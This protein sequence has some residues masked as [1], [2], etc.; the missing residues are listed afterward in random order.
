MTP[1]RWQAIRALADRLTD[2][3][4]SRRWTELDAACE[5]DDAL[6]DEVLALIDDRKI[7]PEFLQPVSPS[8]A[9]SVLAETVAV[10][11]V[12]RR[13]G[14]YRLSEIIAVGGMGTVYRGLRD[15][16]RFD[17][18]V[19]IKIPHQPLV[20]DEARRRFARELQ[21]V[22]RLE[23]PH[24]ARLLD[25]GVVHEH[26]AYLVMEL[27]DG[28]PLHRCCREHRLTIDQRLTLFGCVCDAV[29]FAHQNLVVHRD[30]KP[31]NILVTKD[32]QV[33][34]VDFGIARLLDD[35]GADDG[36]E[37]TRTAW[38]AFTP[39]YASPEQ[40]RG[41]PVTVAGEVY[42]LGVVLYELLSGRRPYD[43]AGLG[44][45]ELERVIGQVDPT[46]PS[47]AVAADLTTTRP[48]GSAGDPSHDARALRA[49]Q[50]QLEGDL[51]TIVL[52]AL[53]KDPARRYPSVRELAA[54]IDRH[55]HGYPVLARRDSLV[56]RGRKFVRRNLAAVLAVGVIMLSL[57]GGMVVATCGVVRAQRSARIAAA[58]SARADAAA[59]RAMEIA[60]MLEGL[61]MSADPLGPHGSDVRVRDLLAEAE[62]RIDGELSGKPDLQ[63]VLHRIVGSGY[64][65][66][67]LLQ[68]AEP[69]LRAAVAYHEAALD[70]GPNARAGTPPGA[71]PVERAKATEALAQWLAASGDVA[72]AETLF[73]RALAS[74]Q[75]LPSAPDTATAEARIA[76]AD[77]LRR[78]QQYDEAEE[79]LRAALAI[80]R[81]V[82]GQEHPQVAD[83]LDR[84][85]TVRGASNDD[86]EAEALLRQ[87]LAIRLAA[88]GASSPA[89]AT[90][91]YQLARLHTRRGEVEQADVCYGEVM[92]IYEALAP[93][94]RIALIRPLFEWTGVLQQRG[95]TVE[96]EALLVDALAVTTDE[97]PPW[98]YIRLLTAQR[99]SALLSSQGR[100]AEAEPHLLEV[101]R[102]LCQLIGPD[103]P[104]AKSVR[105]ILVELYQRWGHPERQAVLEAQSTADPSDRAAPRRE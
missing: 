54:D 104:S 46:P 16:G 99:Y 7:Q 53:H 105:Q 68:D 96:A 95:R 23:H 9:G 58:E 81:D 30:L 48:D 36:P 100:Y 65:R 6:R 73:R 78:Q 89:A 62:R 13:I 39:Q 22:A 59:G 33:K 15:D 71:D 103:H 77:V 79:H 34:L 57:I 63:A 64:K 80:R 67:G 82:L 50:R 42:S 25:G 21:A 70:A 38:R 11:A 32:G 92:R 2:L 10:E 5:D 37:T 56:Y 19:A 88:F 43:L 87:A 27:V 4:L 18:Q 94:D 1:E 35:A 69:H 86:A 55:V 60:D 93:R 28:I 40:I 29:Q 51:D 17:Q 76:L 47:A 44:P 12:G 91:H 84:L 61:L 75:S 85:A 45:G 20:S 101:Y 8:W 3:P 98:H 72:G 83:V 41:E 66:L 74:R 31:E 97:L 14:P 49:E 26:T 102:G 24:I 52:K 90:S